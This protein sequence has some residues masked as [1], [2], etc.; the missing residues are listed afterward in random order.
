MYATAQMIQKLNRTMQQERI[1]HLTILARLSLLYSSDRQLSYISSTNAQ[2]HCCDLPRQ[3][4]GESFGFLFVD[5]HT[6]Q[7]EFLGETDTTE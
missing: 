2:D 6:H 1:S 3:F 4:D 7:S 5:P